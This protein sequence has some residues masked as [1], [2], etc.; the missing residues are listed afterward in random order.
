MP[1]G[2][3]SV[4]SLRL[5]FVGLAEQ[6]GANIRQLCRRFGISP[7]TGYKWISR[8]AESGR[9]GL[10]DQSRRPLRS[11][12]RSAE[13]LEARVL[14]LRD[15][16]PDWGG[17]KLRALLLDEGREAVPSAPTITAILRR[18]GR[19]D[20]SRAGQPNAW[21]RFEHEAPNQLW[22]MDFKGDF[23]L[24]DRQRSRCHPLTLLDDHSRFNLCLQAC[25]NEQEQTVQDTLTGV[26]RRYG[27]PLRISAD[28]GS[29]WG[30]TRTE[31]LTA[32]G[33]WLVRLGIRL[34]HSRP[35]HPQ[36]QGK[37]ERFHRT[38]KVELLARQSF[39]SMAAAQAA[40]DRWRERY[41]LVRPH[42]ALGQR[43]P[44]TRYVPSPRPFPELLAPIEYDSTDHVRKVQTKGVIHFRGAEYRV[45][46]GLIGL[47]VA[48][49]ATTEEG[50]WEV[51]FCRQRVC[52]ITLPGARS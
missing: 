48:V 38:L 30:N 49:R 10:E 29:P 35:Y 17:R 23:A 21:Q 47:P 52:A 44:V 28:N 8:F 46:R 11:P 19:L 7:K 45:G 12:A 26:F 41:N 42:E 34:G 43:P 15:S 27:L 37:D 6:P 4:S 40:F 3:V 14:S 16:Y 51:F 9:A 32:L 39:D 13:A 33:A 1:W 24:V 25:A 36:T 2:E 31:S 50:Q 5:E 22:Q 20:P 18:H